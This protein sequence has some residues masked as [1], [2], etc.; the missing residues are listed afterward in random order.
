MLPIDD[1]AAEAPPSTASPLALKSLRQQQQ[2]Q[3]QRQSRLIYI[4]CLIATVFFLSFSPLTSFF[5]VMLLWQPGLG[6]NRETV[7]RQLMKRTL[8]HTNTD[9]TQSPVNGWKKE[10]KGKKTAHRW[11]EEADLGQTDRNGRKKNCR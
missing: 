11:R 4:Y 5:L 3:Q 1:D 2:Q 9:K 6:Q 7:E 8:T 10:K